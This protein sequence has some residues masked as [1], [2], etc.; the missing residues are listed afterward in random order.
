MI[1]RERTSNEFMTVS[2][3]DKIDKEVSDENKHR[4]AGH[5]FVLVILLTSLSLVMLEG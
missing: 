3:I 1:F 5:N 4:K 2:K